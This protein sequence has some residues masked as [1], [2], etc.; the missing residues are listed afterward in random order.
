MIDVRKQDTAASASPLLV[1]LT[2]V[3]TTLKTHLAATLLCCA[4]SLML[5]GSEPF[6]FETLRYKAKLLAAQD[7][8]STQQEVPESLRSPAL[9][10]DDYRSIRFRPEKS[11]WLKEELP[12]QLQF[13]HP[14][15]IHN[16]SVQL[17]EL[18]GKES[19]PI[20][21]KQTL[22]DY[23]QVDLKNLPSNLGYSGFR[24]HTRLNSPA[25]FD[26][27]AVFQGASYFRALCT[28]AV[29]G[30]SARG[31]ALDTAEGSGEEFP[32][33]E[34]FWIEKPKAASKSI[35]VL[36]LLNS[37]SVVGAYAF[38]ITPGEETCMQVH[39]TLYLR[40]PVKTLGIAPLTSM[41]WHGENSENH[42]SDFRPEVHDS[43]G[44]LLRRGDGEWLW[45]ALWNPQSLRSSAFA[46]QNPK[47]FGLLQRDRKFSNY[48]DLEANY[49]SRPSLWVEP[50]GN[51]GKGHIRLIELPTPD[52][53]NDN[54]V[55]FWQPE[56]CAAPGEAMDFE[57]KLHWFLEGS[58]KPPAG[59]TTATRL[60]HSLTHEPEL[61]RFVVDF[62]GSYLH[63][64]GED[65]SIEAII[66]VG[67][68]AELM[69]QSLQKNKL[70]GT[71]RLAFALKPS[72]PARPV[73]LRC[74]LRKEAHVLTETW[75]YQWTP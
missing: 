52:E 41:F 48:E 31:L 44:L 21:F 62:D 30:L 38:E 73:E 40:K 32:V 37:P 61:Q 25:Y 65:P 18:K 3:L 75:S 71:W 56:Q 55:A 36:A 51:W 60:G 57:Y 58:I 70:N 43:D 23:S 10:Y 72:G 50:L 33:F 54:I 49:Q 29:Y 2:F 4:G 14:G 8:K 64:Q 68:G 35:R 11:W 16:R 1:T 22:F 69:H 20:P 13:F 12:F 63:N 19:V 27:L 17:N 28:N 45:R 47:G 24:L 59:F 26:E 9:S 34:E 7:Y 67:E 15:F 46:D 42:Y 6:D 66:D 74:F 53:T 39:C 5:Q